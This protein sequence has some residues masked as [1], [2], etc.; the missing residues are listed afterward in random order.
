MSLGYVLVNATR[1]EQI[2]FRHLPASTQREIAGHPAA[3]VVAWYLLEHPGDAIAFVN[4]HDA[5]WPFAIGAFDDLRDYA[6]MTDQVVA[7][8]IAAGIVRDEGKGYVD[9]DDPNVFVRNLTNIWGL[10][11]TVESGRRGS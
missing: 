9:E 5:V 1:R 8:L 11:D 4:D 10:D 3:A 2:A 7:D 6:D